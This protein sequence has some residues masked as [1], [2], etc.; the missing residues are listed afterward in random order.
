M[1]GDLLKT[2]FVEDKQEKAKSD[3]RKERKKYGA[4]KSTVEEFC[5]NNPVFLSSSK[6]LSE[7]DTGDDTFEIY[8]EHP[9]KYALRLTNELYKKCSK[10]IVLKTLSKN[11]RLEIQFNT[12]TLANFYSIS[13]GKDVNIKDLIL[14][15]EIEKIQ[16]MSPE[17]ELIDVYRNLYNPNKESEW[18]GLLEIE[19]KISKQVLDRIGLLGG[20]C[21]SCKIKRK[22]SVNKL[23]SLFV[24]QFIK[25]NKYVVLGDFGIKILTNSDITSHEKVQIISKNKIED[26][27]QKII[28]FMEVYTEFGITY[29]KQKIDIPKDFRTN[30]Y[31]I[32]V[33]FP[34][35]GKTIQ[36]AL[37]DI[38]NSAQFELIPYIVKNGY[39]VGNPF[40]LSRFIMIDI[41]IIRIINKMGLIKQT[42]LSDKIAFFIKNLKQ[43]K[44]M[45]WKPMVF[46]VNYFGNFQDYVISTK[47]D[48]LGEDFSY[49]YYPALHASSG[50]REI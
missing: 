1:F 15:V 47:I 38:Y 25:N 42:F 45:N 6:K 27:I 31:T 43:I 23:K 32:Y 19:E 13:M 30:K 11:K 4:A 21:D 49:P 39:M 9:Y 22:A 36:K 16:Y 33:E 35:L 17:L 50:L 24:E 29:R 18:E 46:G 28:K 26:D 44:D 2:N 37:I 10:Y 41:W 7:I 8:C 20:N 3:I 34:K 12:F 48:R 14:P 5:K 40:V